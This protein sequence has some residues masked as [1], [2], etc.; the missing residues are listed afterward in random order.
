MNKPLLVI[1]SGV[2]GLTTLAKIRKKMP[3]INIIYFADD[4]FL[5]YGNKTEQQLIL[6]ICDIITEF[7]D[8]ICGV[9][10][11]CNTATG[12]AISALRKMFCFP[13]IGTEP[14][15][16]LACKTEGKTAVLVTPLE[17]RQDKFLKLIQGKNVVVK[18]MKNLARIIDDCLLSWVD[19]GVLQKELTDCICGLKDAIKANGVKKIVL[20]CTH[21]VF[22][23]YTNLLLGFELFDGNEGVSDRVCALL[24]DEGNSKITIAF[25]S[26]NKKK[27]QM[28]LRLLNEIMLFD[29]CP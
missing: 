3:N 29:F 1:D 7:E 9:V 17:A 11:A 28:A 12:V 15:V 14:A 20:G 10:L 19:F 23:R 18:E 4:T 6:H 22:L 24:R 13:I 27:S 8:E 25:A 26:G 16:M 2:G 21:Y 5:P